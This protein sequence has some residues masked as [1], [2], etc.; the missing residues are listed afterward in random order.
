MTVSHL[1]MSAALKRKPMSQR[2]VFKAV[3][4]RET[5]LF[6]KCK[7]TSYKVNVA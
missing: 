6:N 7:M 2:D 5:S 1:G 3:D 4:K